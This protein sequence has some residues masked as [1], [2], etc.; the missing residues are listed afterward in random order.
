ME[1]IQN[2]DRAERTLAIWNPSN[3]MNCDPESVY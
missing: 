3:F 2:K 1:M